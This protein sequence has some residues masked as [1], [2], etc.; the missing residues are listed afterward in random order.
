MLALGKKK[1]N[2]QRLPLLSETK[3]KE[4][5]LVYLPRQV[6]SGGTRKCFGTPQTT[7]GT[8]GGRKRGCGG[9]E[10]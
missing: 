3:S 1:V 8:I 5:V 4:A 6:I 9:G 7:V 10:L 2:P